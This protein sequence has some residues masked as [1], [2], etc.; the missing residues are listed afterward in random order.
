MKPLDPKRVDA[1]LER[2]DQVDRMVTETGLEWLPG[3]IT[4]L[5][6]VTYDMETLAQQGGAGEKIPALL[7]ISERLYGHLLRQVKEAHL[8]PNLTDEM[9]RGASRLGEATAR[10]QL[11]VGSEA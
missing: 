5:E 3:V 6:L 4:Q 10:L 2:L 8:T 7:Q 9:Y 11:S 1:L